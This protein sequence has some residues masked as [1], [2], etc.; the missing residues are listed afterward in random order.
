MAIATVVPI[1]TSVGL[2]IVLEYERAMLRDSHT[3]M[4]YTSLEAYIAAKVLTE[5]LKHAPPNPTRAGLVKSLESL[6]KY[7]VGGFVVSFAPGDNH[8]SDF[9]NVAVISGNGKFR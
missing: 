1:Y 9:V 5:G 3:E 2:P 4:S 7:D 8:G 6:N